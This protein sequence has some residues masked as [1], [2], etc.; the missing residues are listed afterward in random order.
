MKFA[1]VKGVGAAS[2]YEPRKT[3]NN[4]SYFTDGYRLVLWVS[5]RPVSFSDAENLKWEQLIKGTKDN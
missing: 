3:F 2:I 5:S 4:D 1:H